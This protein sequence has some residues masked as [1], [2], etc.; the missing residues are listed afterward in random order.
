MSQ[1]SEGMIGMTGRIYTLVP[2]ERLRHDPAPVAALYR[3]HGSAAPRMLRARLADLAR[4]L[5]EASEDLAAR[6]LAALPAHL[7]EAR[8]MAG[9]LGLLSV[10]EVAERA[11]DQVGQPAFLALWARLLRLTEAALNPSH[12][13]LH[14]SL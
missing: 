3:D 6:D 11:A 12:D 2:Q 1:Q 5:S 9:D 8:R 13:L 7:S 4:R 14:S 10:A